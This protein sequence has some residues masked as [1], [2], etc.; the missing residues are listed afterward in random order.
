MHTCHLQHLIYTAVDGSTSPVYISI[1][2]SLMQPWSPDEYLV[3]ALAELMISRVNY[4]YFPVNP[5]VSTNIIE[6]A[7][8]LLTLLGLEYS[9]TLSGK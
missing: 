2:H 1:V 7:E 3:Q 8:I 4:I 9:Q 6:T 5:D